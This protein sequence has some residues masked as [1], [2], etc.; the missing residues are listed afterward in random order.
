MK[1]IGLASFSFT[2]SG[3]VVEPIEDEDDTPWHVQLTQPITL[4][5]GGEDYAYYALC[6]QAASIQAGSLQFAVDADGAL[7]FAVAGG[8]LRQQ[9]RLRGESTAA[10]GCFQFRLGPSVHDYQGRVALD[11]GAFVDRSEVCHVSLRSCAEKP[12]L[13]GL[14]PLRRCYLAAPEAGPSGSGCQQ[15]E[16][17]TG[18]LYGLNTY[19]QETTGKRECLRETRRLKGDTFVYSVGRCEIW[20]CERRAA[21]VTS[22]TSRDTSKEVYSS[23]CEYDEVNT[24]YQGTGRRSPVYIQ[25]WEWN[26]VDIAK[27]CTRF[28]GPNGIG[29]VQISPVT[30]HILGSEWYTKYQPIG[31]GLNS[32]SGNSEQLAKM[33]ATCRAAGVQIMVDVILNHIAAPCAAALEAG[34]TAVMP[35]IGWAGSNYGN[36]RINSEDGWKGPELFHNILGNLMG[37]CPVE[38]PD[39]TCP[40]SEPPGDCTKCDFK[41][42]PDWNT[43]LQSTQ[44]TLAKHLMELHDLGV[45]MLRIDAA[46]YMSETDLAAIIN[47]LPWD[48]VHQEWWGGTPASTRSEAVGHY[49]DQKYGLKIANA[50]GVADVKYMA[51]LLNITQGLDGIPPER[52]VYPLTFHDART[53]EADRFVP[54]YKNGLEFHQQQKF[55][56]AWPHAVAVRLFAGYTFTNMDAGPPGNCGNGKC[57]PYPVYLFEDEEPRCMPTPTQSPLSEE[58]KGY[59]GYVC[60]HR[61]EGIGGLVNF[62]QACRGLPITQIWSS[63]DG[64]AEL[65]QF[66]FRVTSGEHQC[67]AALVR[68]D[69]KKFPNYWGDL[70]DWRLAGMV[71]GL[72]PG[73]YCD[74]ASLTTQRCWDRRRCPREVLIGDD[75]IVVTGVV[76]QGDLLALHTGARLYDA[77]EEFVCNE[78]STDEM[79]HSERRWLSLLLVMVAVLVTLD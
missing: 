54:T 47:Q 3:V 62:R 18:G 2:G 4:G 28:L 21:L 41:G 71:T 65:G 34:S 67:F 5:Q 24:G 53:F 14:L 20:K 23:L 63:Q 26:Y 38:E 61:W 57:Q 69:N 16:V 56:L 27:E 43:G 7:N 13:A 36:R 66:A 6:V 22:A 60:E 52:A 59:E 48:L 15:V 79:S 68:G 30:E 10:A 58:E 39:F 74:L 37:N 12:S 50:L 11:L 75:G 72:P 25:L 42:L 44:D 76:P 8:G 32:R 78:A 73:R 31:F 33:I 17:Q 29:A 70:G 64:N 9:L 55:L 35:C 46:S 51:E 77:S 1:D 49:R 45:T 40:Q 19:G